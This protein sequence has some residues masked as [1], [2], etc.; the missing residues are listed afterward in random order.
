MRLRSDCPIITIVRDHSRRDVPVECFLITVLE[1]GL[2]GLRSQSLIS[3]ITT[4]EA[5]TSYFD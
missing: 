2:W 5:H 1:Y 3:Y 4:K